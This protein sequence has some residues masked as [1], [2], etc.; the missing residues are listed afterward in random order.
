MVDIFLVCQIS[1][2]YMS[3]FFVGLATLLATASNQYQMQDV[4]FLYNL[5]FFTTPPNKA[6]ICCL[7]ISPQ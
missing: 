1:L 3:R 6:I 4:V 7:I 2:G 5:G